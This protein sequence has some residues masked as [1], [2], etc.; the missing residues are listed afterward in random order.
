MD[1]ILTGQNNNREDPLYGY[2]HTAFSL[3]DYGPA[4]KGF[5]SYDRGSNPGYKVDINIYL[6]RYML[7][8]WQRVK[9]HEGVDRKDWYDAAVNAIDWAVS[10]QNS[11]GGLP[12]K[13]S[14]VPLE[15]QEG[16]KTD[17]GVCGQ[18]SRI[19]CVAGAQ[20]G[21]YGRLEF[22]CHPDAGKPRHGLL[23]LTHH[24]VESP[25]GRQPDVIVEIALAGLPQAY[26][27][28]VGLGAPPAIGGRSK[29]E[30]SVLPRT[31][32]LTVTMPT[33]CPEAR[34]NR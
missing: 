30:L 10:Q 20:L 5:N 1:F 4:G 7:L 21:F 28:P 33:V 18:R 26:P 9:S 12:Q 32:A 17:G 11:D 25:L 29:A 13:L 19:G 27:R 8:M 23:N 14:F 6:G 22:G 24:L 3:V 15:F 2:I 34:S 16:R 31:V